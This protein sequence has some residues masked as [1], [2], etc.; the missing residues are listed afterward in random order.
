MLSYS[1]AMAKKTKLVKPTLV[2]SILSPDLAAWTR[3]Q[4]AA[5]GLPV[6]TWLRRLLMLKRREIGGK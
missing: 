3:E 2:Q 6:G 4:A 1:K 5:E